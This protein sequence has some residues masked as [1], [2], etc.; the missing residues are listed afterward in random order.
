MAELE[1]VDNPQ[2]SRY[3]GRLDGV[4]VGFCDYVERDGQAIFP[5]TET[6]PAH[7]GRGFAEAIVRVAVDDAE[8]RGLTIVPQCWFVAAYLNARKQP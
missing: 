5:H 7:R 1:V 6:L 4:L 2:L 8:Q 3:E